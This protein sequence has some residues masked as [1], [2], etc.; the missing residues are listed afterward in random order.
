MPNT[1]QCRGVTAINKPVEDLANDEPLAPPSRRALRAA[2]SLMLLV[3]PL[4][5]YWLLFRKMG[6]SQT[7]DQIRQAQR[8]P[9]LVAVAASLIAAVVMNSLVWQ[10]IL[11]AMGI[12]LS[13]GRAVFAE[14][15]SLPLRMLL[16]A[17]SGE[18]FKAMY[19]KSAGLSGLSEGLGSVMFHKIIN[20]IALML[21]SLPAVMTAEGA[22]VRKLLIFL[23]VGLWV[24]L[25]PRWVQ[26]LTQRTSRPLPE[27]LRN[28]LSRVVGALGKTSI[29]RK[30]GL[31]VM[32]VVF[33]SAHLI[34][35]TMIFR[36]LG[37]DVPLSMLC[38]YI[39]VAVLVG[40]VPIALYGLGTREAAFVFFFSATVGEQPAMAAA[41]LF[42][43]IQFLLPVLIGSALTWPFVKTVLG[44]RATS[45]DYRRRV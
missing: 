5:V 14:N 34:S 33:Q 39:P 9:L 20:V 37:A 15:A 40:I 13:F 17:K 41:L 8:G 44:T 24:Y 30:L 2:Q 31:L 1:G 12:R 32:A 43:G 19:I 6:F 3:V 27:R 25:W 22:T 10:Q 36:S 45:S 42:T 26:S 38:A 16:P 4:L 18:V 7:V 21:L 11:A 35:V 28:A 29:A 23:A